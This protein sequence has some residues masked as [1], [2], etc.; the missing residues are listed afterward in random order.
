MAFEFIA[1]EIRGPVGV[2]RLNRPRARN[3]LNNQ[4]LHEL[5]EALEALD[6]DSAVGAIVLTGGDSFAAGADIKEMAGQSAAEMLAGGF[7]AC[8]ARLTR[9]GKPVIAAV[10]GWALGGGCELALACDMIVASDT[11]KFGQP[12][13]TIGAIPGAGGTQRLPRAVGKSLA[14]EMILNNRVLTADEALRLGMVNRVVPPSRCLEEAID[15]AR[16]IADRAPLAV[17]SAKR[18]INLAYELPL[19]EALEQE[20]KEFH[21]LFDTM[22]RIEG[23]KAF[24]EKRA[25]IWEGR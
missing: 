3:A 14:M 6:A 16:Q 17:R 8:F 13:V 25:A 2:V 7:I 23:M 22:D 24:A 1:Q 20:R 9:I 11:A 19:A 12:E 21:A 15:L 5:M 4:L 18:L 10:S